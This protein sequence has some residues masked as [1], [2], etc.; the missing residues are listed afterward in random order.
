MARSSPYGPIQPEITSCISLLEIMQYLDTG[1][2]PAIMQVTV[3]AR[4]TKVA[5]G[6]TKI[7]DCE[8][9]VQGKKVESKKIISPNH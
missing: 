3:I 2:F 6:S 4:Q 5:A 1:D 8:L 7:D 9:K